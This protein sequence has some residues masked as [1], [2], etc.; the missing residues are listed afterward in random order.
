MEILVG[1]RSLATDSS[2]CPTH[3]VTSDNAHL[4]VPDLLI[5]KRSYNSCIES[6][7]FPLLKSWI[8]LL[9]TEKNVS[10]KKMHMMAEFN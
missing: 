8:K 6:K 7:T 3:Q 2:Q 9:K 5:F 1:W 4:V 10:Y